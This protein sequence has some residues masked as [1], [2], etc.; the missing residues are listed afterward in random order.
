MASLPSFS[1]LYATS[2][3]VKVYMMLLHVS[4]YTRVAVAFYAF[5]HLFALDLENRPDPEST[6]LTFCCP[7]IVTWAFE[8]GLQ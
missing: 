5:T 1:V 4:Q 3:L 2:N 8:S 7:L 6:S